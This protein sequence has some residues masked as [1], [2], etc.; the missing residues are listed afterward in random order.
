MSSSAVKPQI[1]GRGGYGHVISLDGSRVAK[2]QRSDAVLDPGVSCAALREMVALSRLDGGSRMGRVLLD[3][4]GTCAIEIQRFERTLLDV[5][6]ESKYRGLPGP[7]LDSTLRDV[8]MELHRAHSQGMI[9]RDLKP[10]NVMYDRE[11]RAHVID[12]GMSRWAMD[13]DGSEAGQGPWTPGMSTIWY[14]APELF[15]GDDYGPAVDMWSLGVMF[16]EMLTGRCPFR[17]KTELAQIRNFVEV[18]GLPPPDGLD[19]WPFPERSRK[20]E[21][22]RTHTWAVASSRI[23]SRV[24]AADLINRLIRWDPASRMSSA[25]ARELLL[26]QSDPSVPHVPHVPRIPRHPPTPAAA[27]HPACY[28]ESKLLY[29]ICRVIIPLCLR[30]RLLQGTV[31]WMASRFLRTALERSPEMS[32]RVLLVNALGCLDVANK[33]AGTQSTSVFRNLSIMDAR[34][35]EV[36]LVNEVLGLEG[37]HKAMDECPLTNLRRA[38]S[39]LSPN[40]PLPPHRHHGTLLSPSRRPPAPGCASPMHPYPVAMAVL[41]AL[42]VCQPDVALQ[43]ANASVHHV[44]AISMYACT[45]R[46]PGLGFPRT[47]ASISQL[48]R[49]CLSRVLNGRGRG[50]MASTAWQTL[51]PK[52]YAKLRQ[53]HVLRRRLSV[54][55][56]P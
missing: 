39:H 44:A 20:Q 53:D 48:V 28:P 33:I 6:R 49:L 21:P 47:S 54:Q 7:L 12:W 3:R 10:E 36:R 38:M 26:A 15:T 55:T 25:M 42:L 9:H 5:I 52:I 34:S 19:R 31:L 45:G 2:I 41:D 11:G 30:C 8:V 32:R 22:D 13:G 29:G 16:V 27:L 23:R 46:Q 37:L 43:V 17:G 14:R 18:L 1:L 50:R 35:V 4:D 40:Q 24:G 51:H 56:V